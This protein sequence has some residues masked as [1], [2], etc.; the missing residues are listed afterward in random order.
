[1]MKITCFCELIKNDYVF[2][3][4]L[5]NILQLLGRC[6]AELVSASHTQSELLCKSAAKYVGSRNKFGMTSGIYPFLINSLN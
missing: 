2:I 5:F 4:N 3:L 1:M 6:H